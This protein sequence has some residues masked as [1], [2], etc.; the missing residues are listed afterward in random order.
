LETQILEKV[1]FLIILRKKRQKIGNYPGVTVEKSEGFFTFLNNNFNI[2]DLPGIY[3]LSTHTEEELITRDFILN[4][5]PDVIINI[6]DS[7]YI[8]RSLFLTTQIMELNVP[9]ILI[10]NKIDLA[11]KHGIKIDIE[12]MKKELNVEVMSAVAYK[13]KGT[14]KIL[15]AILD[16]TINKKKSKGIFLKFSKN[17]EKEISNIEKALKYRTRWNALK[18]LEN[19]V[20]DEKKFSKKTMDQVINSKKKLNIKNIEEEIILQR[21][22]FLEKISK[23]F[24]MEKKIKNNFSD[25]LDKILL[26]KYL[27]FPIFFIIMFLVFQSTF[28]IGAYPTKFLEISFSKLIYFVSSLFQKDNFFHSFFVDGVLSGVLSVLAFLP[29][30]LLLFILI[31]ILEETGYMARAAFLMD[32]IMNKVGLHGRSFLPMLI[33]FGCTVPAIMSTRVLDNKRDKFLVI[34]VLPFICCSAKLAVFTLILPAFFSPFLS[35]ILLFFLYFLGIFFAILVIKFFRKIIYKGKNSSFLMEMPYYHMPSFKNIFLDTI[36][37]ASFYI[38]KA[39]TLILL[40]T[41]FLWILTV[42]PKK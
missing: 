12:K 18:L 14:K 25:K 22:K 9:I 3:N 2:I 42:L 36:T 1:L 29:N 26:N 24:I 7:T 15:K 27:G 23:N 33:S 38:K 34:L 16:I 41:S 5:K 11:S 4:E 32:R 13:K 19:E 30:I 39:G 6:L 35:G 10:C 31:S 37:K 28:S 40:F 20:L 8:E 17:I 21:H